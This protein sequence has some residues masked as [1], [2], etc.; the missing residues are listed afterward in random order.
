MGVKSGIKARWVGVWAWSRNIVPTA[1]PPTGPRTGAE[2]GTLEAG[3]EDGNGRRPGRLP[4][5]ENHVKGSTASIPATPAK[6][7]HCEPSQ[8]TSSLDL[9]PLPFSPPRLTPHYA[10][11][12]RSPPVLLPSSPTLRPRWPPS[13]SG[14][15]SR[16]PTILSPKPSN[17][18][19]TNR[20]RTAL[21]GSVSRRMP[22]A[23]PR[24]LTTTLLSRGELSNDARKPSRFFFLV[25]SHFS[26]SPTSS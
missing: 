15:S 16:I 20:P 1:V 3:T 11:S 25:R 6:L 23:Y 13:P 22:Y 9:R 17:R 14:L 18:P 19:P 26:L 5:K 21:L 12:A 24:R 8:L 7:C 10:P 2:R 4:G